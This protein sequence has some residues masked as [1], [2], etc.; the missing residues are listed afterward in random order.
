M[1]TIKLTLAAALIAVSSQAS[2]TY[3]EVTPPQK[4]PVISEPTPSSGGGSNAGALAL[5]LGIGAVVVFANRPRDRTPPADEPRPMV[6]PQTCMAKVG[7]T[8]I[9]VACPE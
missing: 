1:K 8:E 7:S 2:A 3:T 4:P 6:R 9:I 5:L